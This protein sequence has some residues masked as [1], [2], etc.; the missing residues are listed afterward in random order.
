MFGVAGRQEP[1]IN[2]KGGVEIQVL[3]NRLKYSGPQMTISGR[4]VQAEVPSKTRL[5]RLIA[6][7]TKCLREEMLKASLK[8]FTWLTLIWN[9]NRDRNAKISAFLWNKGWCRILWKQ[10]KQSWKD[11]QMIYIQIS[12]H[13]AVP[14]LNQMFSG[15][16]IIHHL[17]QGHQESL[18]EPVAGLPVLSWKDISVRNI[19]NYAK[20]LS[21][22]KIWRLPRSER[23]QTPEYA[24]QW[25]I[26][27]VRQKLGETYK[28]SEQGHQAVPCWDLLAQERYTEPYKVRTVEMA[29]LFTR[30]NCTHLS[31]DLKM[32]SPKEV[33][34]TGAG[35]VVQVTVNLQRY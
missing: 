24:I 10:A 28:I 11:Y 33:L 15:I 26:H 18:L 17:A 3:T 5:A 9:S 4:S 16:C 35:N 2:Y 23:S 22:R 19:P 14:S 25:K 12:V 8:N 31:E 30:E 21:V 1:Q 27:W 7:K 20:G 32:T 6:E 34:R 13:G 29:Q